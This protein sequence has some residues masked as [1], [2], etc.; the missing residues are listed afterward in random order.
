MQLDGELDLQ[1]GSA[2]RHSLAK[3]E[4]AV[5]LTQALF[6]Q[7]EAA[8]E[9]L[10][11]GKSMTVDAALERFLNPTPSVEDLPTLTK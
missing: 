4:V 8:T 11:V 7:L 10:D 2:K 3:R 5:R 9:R 6:G 1:A